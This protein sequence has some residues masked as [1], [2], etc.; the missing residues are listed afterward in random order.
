[1]PMNSPF[2]NI[3]IVTRP[4]TP[5]IQNT[6]HTLIHFLQGHGLTVYLD[7]IGIE[8]RCIYVQDTVGCHI[9]SKSDLGKHCDLVIVLGGDGT[10]LSVAREIAPRAVPVIGINQ[11]HLGFLTQIP[12]ENMTEEL[13][14]VLEGK[15]RPE[16]RILIEAAL[17]RDGQTFH[18][19]L[20]LN[21]AVLSRGGAGQMI[22]FEVFINQEFV[23]TQRSDGL[24]VSTPTGSTAYSLAAGGPIMQAGLPAFTLVPIC[25]QSMT[26][27]PIAIPDT[28]EIEIL[29]TQSGDARVHFDGQSFIDVQNL[30]RIIIRRYHN[31]LRILHPTDYQYF[32][33]LRQKLHWGEQLV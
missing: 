25:P 20:A 26:N 5:E 29:V 14:P 19:A 27:R 31:P 24:I 15:Y 6:A 9:V 28:S 23:Y 33:T 7:E 21:D 13:L 11:G 4:N 10:F 1:M 2:H 30:D 3:G 12:R 17:V 22:E 32:R 16:E 18:R 8:E